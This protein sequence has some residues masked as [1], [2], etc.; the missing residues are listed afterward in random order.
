MNVETMRLSFSELGEEGMAHLFEKQFDADK[1]EI[2][3]LEIESISGSNVQVQSK[4][5]KWRKNIVMIKIF[6]LWLLHA[7]EILIFESR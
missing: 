7:K 5:S 6:I 3:P 1:N 4:I 2:D